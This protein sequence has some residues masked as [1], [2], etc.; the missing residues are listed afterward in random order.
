MPLFLIDSFQLLA[1][2]GRPTGPAWKASRGATDWRDAAISSRNDLLS[3]AC[4]WQTT[5]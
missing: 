4:L 5:L 1:V 2:G 3:A